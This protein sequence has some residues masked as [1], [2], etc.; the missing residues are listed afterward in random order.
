MTLVAVVTYK[1]RFMKTLHLLKSAVAVAAI[2]VAGSAAAV[3]ISVGFNFIGFGTVFTG[4]G[5]GGDIS[6]STTVTASGGFGYL[7]N[8][9]DLINTTN[10]IGLS[11]GDFISLSNPMPLTLGSSFIKSFIINGVTFTENLT[12]S[13]VTV[14]NS[15]RAITATGTIDDGAGGFDPTTVFFSASYTQN[16]GPSGQINASFNN[17]TVPPPVI[18]EPA[19]LALVG[20]ALAGVGLTARRR[21]AAK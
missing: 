16:G 14:G 4:N 21:R 8:G 11:L 12:I 7:V 10:N 3:P 1:V 5:A 9:I 15:S 2:A 19:S 17:S 18:P 6:T 20:L 13:S